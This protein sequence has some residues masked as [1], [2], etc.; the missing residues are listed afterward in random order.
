MAGNGQEARPHRARPALQ[1]GDKSEIGDVIRRTYTETIV[2]TT[3]IVTKRN[4]DAVIALDRILKSDYA[5]LGRIFGGRVDASISRYAKRKAFPDN[6]ELA[7]DLALMQG[8]Q[9]G[10][11]A[12]V[13]YSISALPETDYKPR[14]A[15]DRIGY[16]LTAVKD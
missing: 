16:F 10:Q 8:S 14:V 13:H 15:D 5:S 4:G 7:V 11:R 9:G 6:L 2:L 12:R 3:P 1:A